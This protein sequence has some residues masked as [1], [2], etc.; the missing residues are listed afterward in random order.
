MVESQDRAFNS[1][2]KGLLAMTVTIIS[3]LIKVNNL[4]CMLNNK[5]NK[6]F[7]SEYCALLKIPY[8]SYK[9]EW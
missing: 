8:R 4:M 2:K 1:G 3:A 5:W 9:Q 6:I 7:K